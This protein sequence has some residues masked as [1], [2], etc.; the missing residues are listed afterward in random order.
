LTDC[1]IDRHTPSLYI[2]G[3]VQLKIDGRWLNVGAAGDFVALTPQTMC[4]IQAG[5][6]S[7]THYRLI[8]NRTSFERAVRDAAP[9]STDIIIWLPG[10]AP[11]WWRTSIEQ[12]LA[13]VPLPA[14]ISCDTDPDG[15]QIALDASAL[16]TARLLAWEPYEMSVEDVQEALHTLPMTE[17][18]I[19]LANRLLEAS[20]I[21]SDLAAL[22]QWCVLH[23]AKAEQENWV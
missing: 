7:A 12:L 2:G 9:I 10:Y 3:D 16:W 13:A 15:V 1:G 5:T 11:N 21:P 4:K 18:D 8:E 19:R 20:D 14:R 6:T 23:R 17:R 22:L